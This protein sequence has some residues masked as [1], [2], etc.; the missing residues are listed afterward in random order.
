MRSCS[1]VWFPFALCFILASGGQPT[2]ARSRAVDEAMTQVDQVIAAGPFKSYWQSLESYTVP[3]WYKDAKFGILIHWG[4]DAVPA[5][6]DWYFG[7][8]YQKDH[9]VHKHH[10]ETYGPVTKFGYKD[11]IPLLTFD[12]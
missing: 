5:F 6:D 1:S 8:M 4:V 3:E 2:G 9:K 10:I 11:F 7:N 12:K